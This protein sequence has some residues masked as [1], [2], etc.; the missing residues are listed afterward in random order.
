MVKG[1]NAGI[2]RSPLVRIQPEDKFFL[3]VPTK[4]KDY[5]NMIKN[6]L[7]KWKDRSHAS[8]TDEEIENLSETEYQSYIQ[9]R[10]QVNLEHMV[11]EGFIAKELNEEGNVVYRKKSDEELLAEIEN[12]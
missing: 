1:Q 5:I 11:A 7:S 4:N 12:L 6:T 9:W 2:K 3:E 10:V 8:I